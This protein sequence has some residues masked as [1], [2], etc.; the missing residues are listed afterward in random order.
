MNLTTISLLSFSNSALFRVRKTEYT[1]K[2]EPIS[3]AGVFSVFRGK[4]L[5][6]LLG[7]NCDINE[8]SRRV[9][10]YNEE[11][12]NAHGKCS[13]KIAEIMYELDSIKQLGLYNCELSNRQ[14]RSHI[15][16]NQGECYPGTTKLIIENH[17]FMAIQI[18]CNLSTDRSRVG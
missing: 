3:R 15:E 7:F 6:Q 17:A 10:K 14:I 13:N 16:R 12:V 18:N 8:I 5:S 1:P 4:S 9:Q 2:P 11:V